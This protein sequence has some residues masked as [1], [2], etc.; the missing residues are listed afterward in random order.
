MRT[1]SNLYSWID[2]LPPAVKDAV[3]ARLRARRV[4]N[5]GTVY[6][7]GDASRECY[8]IARGRVRFSNYSAAGK[9]I[10]MAEFRTGDCFGEMGLLDGLPRFN[11]AYA[12]GDTELMVLSR[13]AFQALYRDHREIAECLN[14]HLCLRVRTV[15]LN[16]E[17]A[18]LLTLRERLAR[19][20]MRL[21]SSHAAVNRAD[22]IGIDHL[23][24]QNLAHMLGA[25]RQGVS[26]ELK[27]LERD[28][29]IELGY[30]GLTVPS[31]AALD[32]QFG[33][34]L[35]GVPVVPVYDR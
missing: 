2:G 10:Q 26:R 33:P 1:V 5:G 11:N 34:L 6:A 23:S 29:F 35:G 21:A 3:E 12:V 24:H 16:A 20:L 27:S 22:R 4:A 18:A 32:R 8:V 14:V 9:Q 13:R 15:Y 17:D 7:L 19:L 25:T 31:I 28:G 30:G